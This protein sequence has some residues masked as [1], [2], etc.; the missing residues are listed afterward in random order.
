METD[1]DGHKPVCWQMIAEINRWRQFLIVKARR[2]DTFS[3][4]TA[5]SYLSSFRPERACA[6]PRCRG[7]FYTRPKLAINPMHFRRG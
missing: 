1:K 6:V 5:W 2:F 7:G 4:S 3:P